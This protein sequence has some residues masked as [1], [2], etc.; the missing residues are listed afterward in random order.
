VLALL[1]YF[2]PRLQVSR[3]VEYDSS[4]RACGTGG[5]IRTISRTAGR[6]AVR[7]SAALLVWSVPGCD[8][9]KPAPAAAHEPARLSIRSTAFADGQ[10][11]PKRY[12]RDGDDVSPPLAWCGAP[13]KTKE[14]ALIVD[15]RDAPDRPWVHWVIYKIPAGTTALPEGAALLEKLSAPPGAVQGNNSWRSLGYRGPHPPEGHGAHHYRFRIYALDRLV[16]LRPG[17]DKDALTAAM[18]GHI[19]AKGELIGTYQR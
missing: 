8:R 16:D 7:A 12:T 10:P 19:L 13:A 6:V 17:A 4:F 11:I 5:M 9:T 14:L 15:D 2:R 1:F 18:R 3:R